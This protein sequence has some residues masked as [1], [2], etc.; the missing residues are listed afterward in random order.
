MKNFK[1][2]ALSHSET[3]VSF[4]TGAGAF[5]TYAYALD[6]L[7]QWL[8]VYTNIAVGVGILVVATFLRVPFMTPFLIGSSVIFL[9]DGIMDVFSGRVTA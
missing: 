9:I 6:R 5:I 8:G 3:A 7:P 4:M 2:G 1:V